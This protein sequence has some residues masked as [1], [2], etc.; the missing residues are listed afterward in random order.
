MGSIVEV[1]CSEDEWLCTRLANRWRAS[2]TFNNWGS[3][4]LSCLESLALHAADDTRLT[5]QPHF[6]I[7]ASEPMR[8]NFFHVIT[9][10]S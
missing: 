5:W 7:D 1:A 10:T 8:A 2:N 6:K 3:D 4:K 9:C